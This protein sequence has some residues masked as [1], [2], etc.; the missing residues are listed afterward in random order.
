MTATRTITLDGKPLSIEQVRL[1]A[2]EGAQVALAAEA[3]ARIDA[4]RAAIEG[5]AASGSAVYGVN[6]GFG[7]LAHQRVGAGELAALQA[8]LV[9]SHA[10]G[11]GDPLPEP[12]VRAMLL[13][14][15]ASLSRGASG[16]RCVVVER[17]AEL[18]NHGLVPVVPER[19]SVGAS[20]D[21]APLAH[22]CHPLL[23]EGEVWQSGRRVAAGDAMRAK[24]VKPISL[25]A[26]EGLA[27]LNGTHLMAALGA[28]AFAELEPVLEAAI[29]ATAMAIDACLASSAPLDARIHAARRQPGQI[30]VAERVAHLLHGSQIGPSHANNDPR[31]QDPYALRC[32]PQVLGAAMDQ[33][34]AQRCVIEHELGAVTDNPLVV[35]AAGSG[36]DVVSGG[37]FHG[38]PLAIAMDAAKVALCHVA[39]VSERRVFW[40]LGGFDRVNPVKPY[41]ADNPGVESG[42]MITQY[43]AAACVNELQSLAHPASVGNV[44][45]CGGIEDYNSFGP[46]AGRQ[47]LRAVRLAREVIAIELLVMTQAIEAHRPKRSGEGVERLHAAVR[48][49]VKPLQGDRSPAPDMA[50]LAAA[51]EQGSLLR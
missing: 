5:V 22:A 44:G 25:E 7:S 24:G 2:C 28:L 34:R 20:G 26:K 9:R 33:L 8:N 10:A 3:R 30:V 23:G 12:V 38:M 16:V 31:V 49:V 51:I 39:A 43:A 36:F 11:V 14:L 21:L 40:V 41:L 42:L 45:T 32:A 4:A 15:A 47:L 1:V 17:I 19:G 35:P 37:N 29:G 13:L 18:L 46:L 48:K 50:A 27:L 6:T